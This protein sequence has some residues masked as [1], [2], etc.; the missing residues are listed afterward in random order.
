MNEEQEKLDKEKLERQY[1]NVEKN[2]DSAKE[3]PKVVEEIEPEAKDS[4]Y[5][6]WFR[7]QHTTTQKIVKMDQDSLEIGAQ[8]TGRVKVYGN[9]NDK[10]AFAAKVKEA[11]EVLDGAQQAVKKLNGA[12]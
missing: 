5:R 4:L 8:A 11:L 12:D 9:F 10:K 1:G 2:T 7:D 6:K 3:T